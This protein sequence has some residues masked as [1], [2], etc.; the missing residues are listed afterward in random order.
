M[1]YGY[2]VIGQHTPETPS[3]VSKPVTHPPH[4]PLYHQLLGPIRFVKIPLDLS[5]GHSKNY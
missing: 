2:A 3:T 5:L 4:F 1:T